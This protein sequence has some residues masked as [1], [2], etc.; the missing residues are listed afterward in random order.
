MQND[1]ER[2]FIKTKSLEEMIQGATV[3]V[4]TNVL[5]S[6]YQTK[7]VTFETILNILQELVAKNRLKI[8]SN[9]IR[10]FNENRPNRIK[11]ITNEL[12]QF[13][14][15]VDKI[16]NTQPPKKLNKILPAIDVLEDTHTEKV[17]ELQQEFN[18]QL[19]VLKEKGDIFKEELNSL[20]LKLSDYMDN[21]P[22]LLKYE[23]I[24][25]ESYFEPE[26][27][28]TQKE[29]EDEGKKRFTENIPPGFRDKTKSINKYGDLI[30]WLQMCEL[31]ED[32]VF[33][34]F[35]NK[36]DWVY[37][38]NKNNVLG[39]R[40]ELVQEYYEKSG[41]KTV[42]ILHPGKFVELYQGQVE[43][44]VKEDLNDYSVHLSIEETR[45]ALKKKLWS[46]FGGEE[47]ELS[48]MSELL[49]SIRKW[50]DSLLHKCFEMDENVSEHHKAK[51]REIRDKFTNLYYSIDKES[52]S[53]EKLES[54]DEKLM[55]IYHDLMLLV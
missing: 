10:E 14:N 3:I 52:S 32:I 40:R 4:D 22:I 28:L 55:E 41:G 47:P 39:A 19:D 8:P 30:L 13:I 46:R 17:V 44:E 34:T 36:E 20:V 15:T 54:Y 12:Q 31:K 25:R 27:M 9:V 35:D 6:A 45:N 42:K 49:L 16:K 53:M 2:L 48:E 1:L 23:S 11:E 50:E 51:Y 29:L 21:D 37:K 33:I 18:K 43:P 26:T 24:I 38:D 5:L 7:S